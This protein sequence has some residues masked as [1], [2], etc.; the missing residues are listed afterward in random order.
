MF[1]WEVRVL[2]MELY[3]QFWMYVV[4]GYPLVILIPVSFLFDQVLELMAEPLIVQDLL[5]W[6]LFFFGVRVFWFNFFLGFWDVGVF[7]CWLE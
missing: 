3:D 4:L 5:Y 7:W 2:A 1:P 6:V